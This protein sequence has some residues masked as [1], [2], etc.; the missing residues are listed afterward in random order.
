MGPPRVDYTNQLWKKDN[1]GRVKVLRPA[2]VHYGH[3]DIEK[4]SMCY[5]PESIKQKL[6]PYSRPINSSLTL[7]SLR[8]A[9]QPTLNVSSTK[10]TTINQ[11]STYPRRLTLLFS[12]AEP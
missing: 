4:V 11:C 10:D 1:P 3:P 12:L 7:G 5:K 6:T 9:V 8:Q 2:W